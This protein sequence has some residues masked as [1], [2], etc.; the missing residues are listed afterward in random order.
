MTC[1]GRKSWLSGTTHVQ[2]EGRWLLVAQ[3]ICG[4]AL[5]AILLSLGNSHLGKFVSRLTWTS[6]SRQ[7][8]LHSVLVSKI[9]GPQKMGSG[10][11]EAIYMT[12]GPS[13]AGKDTL[14]LGCREKL[15]EE[16]NDKVG[17]T[18]HAGRLAFHPPILLVVC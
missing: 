5:R 12:A 16:H 4:C 6:K 13:G 14:L 17:V 8:G 11:P 7:H 1:R 10:L 15:Q 2:Q 18:T 9:S 3:F